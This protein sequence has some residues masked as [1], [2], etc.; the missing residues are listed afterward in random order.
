MQIVN[1]LLTAVFLAG[2]IWLARKVYHQRKLIE[3]TGKFING[4]RI[5]IMFC[6]VASCMTLFLGF[7][8]VYDLIRSIAMMVMVAL[9]LVLKEGAGQTGLV[10]NGIF[11]SYDAVAHYD[12]KNTKK[13]CALYVIIKENN[14]DINFSIEFNKTSEA[15]LTDL[16]KQKMPKKHQRMKKI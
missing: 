5:F 13:A 15:A 12:I 10:Y 7:Q 1:L 4:Y 8:D 6:L 3:I 9:F 11:Y 16:L 2:S 14:S